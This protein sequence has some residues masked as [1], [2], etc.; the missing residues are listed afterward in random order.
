MKKKDWNVKLKYLLPSKHHPYPVPGHF[1]I[2]KLLESILTCFIIS[3]KKKYKVE[4]N[5]IFRSLILSTRWACPDEKKYESTYKL[6]TFCIIWDVNIKKL[7]CI[8][9]SEL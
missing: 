1:N 6:F 9:S 5:F 8:P 7:V 4:N 2:S 3:K